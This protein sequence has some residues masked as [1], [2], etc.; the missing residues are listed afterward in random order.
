MNVIRLD[1]TSKEYRNIH[2]HIYN[3]CN[4][5]QD[6]ND[7]LDKHTD[8]MAVIKTNLFN[9]VLFSIPENAATKLK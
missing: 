9:D 4:T 8:M 1:D 6:N 2:T 3:N 7:D 5:Y